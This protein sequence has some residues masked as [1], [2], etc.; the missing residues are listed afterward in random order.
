MMPKKYIV[1]DDATGKTVTFMWEGVN[2]PTEEDFANIFAEAQTIQPMQQ[3]PPTSPPPLIPTP[4]PPS[5]PSP[6][7]WQ[8]IL[9]GI[10]SQLPR[11]TGGILGGIAGAPIAPPF[12]TIGGIAAGASFG[13]LLEQAR[14]ALFEKGEA[15]QTLPE[16]AW[17]AGMAGLE[18]SAYGLVGGA[19]TKGVGKVLAPF[20]RKVVPE[21]EGAINFLKTRI[22]PILTPSQTTENRVIAA[23][24][25]I[26]EGSFLGGS[27]LAKFKIRRQGVI[28]EIADDIIDAM[29]RTNPDDLGEAFIKSVEGRWD[30]FR[31]AVTDPIY[32]TVEQISQGVKVS[33]KS[34]KSFTSTLKTI[35]SDIKRI[36]AKSAGDDLVNAIAKLPDDIDFVTAKELRSRL[37]SRINEFSI[38]N[39]QAPAIGKAKQ[40]IKLID[41]EME[42]SLAKSDS[43][44]LDIWREANR[45]YKEGSET[46]NNTFI[47]RII[48]KAD[49]D[50]GGDPESVGRLVFRPGAVTNIR[51][52]KAAVDQ[53]TWEQFQSYITNSL[54]ERSRDAQGN[55]VGKALNEA[56][57]G[58]SGLGKQVLSE[59][60]DPT[61]LKGLDDFAN[62]ATRASF[63]VTGAPGRVWIQ[64][65]QAGAAAGLLFSG[66][67]RKV[68]VVIL[69]GPMVLSRALLNPMIN[70]WLTLGYKLPPGS[71]KAGNMAARIMAAIERSER[72]HRNYMLGDHPFEVR[73]KMMVGEE[74]RRVANMP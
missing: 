70:K 73:Q 40:F 50:F 36:E 6:S 39:K 42:T 34:L 17:K 2:P 26:A 53:K 32:N 3:T 8:S 57:Y 64:L 49:P 38:I 21:A 10:S 30:A 37:L 69:G 51:R 45:L 12:G 22:Q 29:G 62:A 54:V 56:M 23:L 63:E 28:N 47:R 25:N 46:F 58:K 71:V 9:K 5:A 27:R 18:E 68:G 66:P 52:V 41:N 20:A 14:K 31:K 65:A 67:S 11:T 4:P 15:P 44:A 33:T 55:I 35:S 7:I 61:T 74:E 48:K 24:E 1:K 60:F 16:A 13:E 59:V 43:N 72:E 19:A